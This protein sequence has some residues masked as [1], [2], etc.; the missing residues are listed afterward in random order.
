[1]SGFTH[2]EY[3]VETDW[4]AQHLETRMCWCWTAPRI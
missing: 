2:P 3:L 1:M 4:L